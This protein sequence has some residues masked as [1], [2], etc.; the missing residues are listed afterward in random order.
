ME[1]EF[2]VRQILQIAEKLEHNGARFYAK[3]ASLFGDARRRQLCLTLADWRAGRQRTLQQRRQQCRQ[4]QITGEQRDAHDYIQT[5]PSIMADLAVFDEHAFPPNALSGREGLEQIVKD[6]IA[7]T[8]QAITFY[9]GL[10]S[11]ARNRK[12]Q[13]ELDRIIAQE[14]HYVHILDTNRHG[15]GLFYGDAI[16]KL[17]AVT[18]G[19]TEN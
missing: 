3:M 7:R 1:P 8:R 13:A 12:A 6:A 16:G 5:H 14:R 11:F 19:R 15:P 9:Q 4:P 10:K 18:G 2:T 17:L